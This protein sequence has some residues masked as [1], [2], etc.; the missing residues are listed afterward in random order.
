MHAPWLNLV[1]SGFYNVIMWSSERYNFPI[2]FI[3]ENGY[4][5]PGESDSNVALEDHLNDD[6]R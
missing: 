6:F 4:D 1:P 2:I 5:V 3:T